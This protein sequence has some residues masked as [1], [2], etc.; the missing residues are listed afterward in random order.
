MIS[1]SSSGLWAVVNNA[2]ISQWAEI[3]WSSIQ[4]FSSMVDI[5]LFGAIRTTL[6]FLPLV[7]A[8]RGAPLSTRSHFSTLHMFSLLLSALLIQ[9]CA[10]AGRMVFT[11]SIFS[12]LTC[13]NMAAYSVSKRGLEAF[14]DCLRLEMASFGVKVC[15]PGPPP[16]HP[17]P[18]CGVAVAQPANC[19]LLLSGQHHPAWKLWPSYQHPESHELLRCLGQT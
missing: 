13:L 1:S 12:F 17:L 19:C 7:R 6:A 9:A 4:D 18:G 3:E 10:S 5:N 8:S 14:A 16:A 2:G 15:P 11:S